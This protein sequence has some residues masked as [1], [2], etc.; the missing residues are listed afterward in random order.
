MTLPLD[1]AEAVVGM[2]ST[3]DA[4]RLGVV[5]RDCMA[6]TATHA[7]WQNASLVDCGD[8]VDDCVLRFMVS[9]FKQLGVAGVR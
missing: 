3:T 4:V 6:V 8:R 9:R 1:C 5:C 7:R 2:L